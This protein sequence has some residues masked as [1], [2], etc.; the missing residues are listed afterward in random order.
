MNVRILRKV[1]CHSDRVLPVLASLLLELA[2]FN[3]TAYGQTLTVE[4]SCGPAGSAVK[5][6]G[7]GWAEPVPLCDYHFLFDGMAFAPTQPDGLTGP[8][9][10][11]GTIPAGATP[12][13][14]KIKVELR[15]TEDGSL[16]Q[17]RQ[18]NFRVVA[19]N[20]NP[21]KGTNVKPAPG[22]SDATGAVDL[23][24]DPKDV[25]DVTPC[26]RL[27]WIQTL[28]QVG[29]RADGTQQVLTYADFNFPNAA[30]Y[31]SVTVPATGVGVDRLH[32][33]PYPY[34][35]SDNS[36]NSPTS[37][38]NRSGVQNGTPRSANLFDQPGESTFPASST[39]SQIN[40]IRFEF[41][42]NIFCAE[43]QNRGTF[44]G[45][46]VIWRW[47]KQ[48]GTAGTT[49]TATVV[50][51]TR[52]QPSQAFLNALAL[53]DSNRSTWLMPQPSPPAVGGEACQ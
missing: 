10:A 27:A 39:A 49:G 46:Q 40:T 53:W 11:T 14:H 30:A 1:L 35:G 38:T 22:S 51:A 7:S 52:G 23:T 43:G 19:Q 36:G 32:G 13:N 5:I 17:C 8:P 48:R 37:G 3:L 44:P 21:F 18:T 34:Y 31:D 25:C 24:F 41:E 26:T 50:S 16:I 42:S 47:E 12:G 2:L 29:V 28:R 6:G 33:R 15:L 4:P 45:G 20:E 9:N